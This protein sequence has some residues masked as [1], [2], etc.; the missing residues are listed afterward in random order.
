MNSTYI[1]AL[2]ILF[3]AYICLLI[4]I[5]VK[6]GRKNISDEV[7]LAPGRSPKVVPDTVSE[8]PKAKL[9]LDIEF[10]KD[11][12]TGLYRAVTSIKNPVPEEH[13]SY[14]FYLLAD[15]KQIDVRWHEHSPVFEFMFPEERAKIEIVAFVKN[16]NG[17]TFTEKKEIKRID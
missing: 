13:Y 3:S 2:I 5:T 16:E 12:N 11:E 7:V 10:S 8:Q 17:D 1:V 15:R 4:G 6:R 9:E 14:A